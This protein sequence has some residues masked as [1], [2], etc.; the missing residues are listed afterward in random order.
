[1]TEEEQ[2]KWGSHQPALA[3]CLGATVGPVLEIGVGHFS[4]PFLS[5]YCR[6]ADRRLVSIERDGEW[7]GLFKGYTARNHNV[8]NVTTYEDYVAS[9]MQHEWAVC[10][11]D[12]SP[13]GPARS[14]LFSLALPRCQYVVVHDYHADNEE[15]IAPLL[16]G[17][18]HYVY[19]RY[20]PPTLIA[21]VKRDPKQLF[22]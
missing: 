20:E 8:V 7:Y 1:M 15:H 21:S 4:T 19:N 17:V 12:N 2:L 10:F 16:N 9:A 18:N 5:A 22:A 11:I 13:G 6:N 3:A 14:G